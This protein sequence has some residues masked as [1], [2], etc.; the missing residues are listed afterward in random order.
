MS[1]S[2]ELHRGRPMTWEEDER[3]GEDVRAEDIAGP[4][5][6]ARGRGP[7]RQ[8]HDAAARLRQGIEAARVSLTGEEPGEVPLGIGMVHVGLAAVLA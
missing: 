8:Q 7:S 6:V 4:A 3:L 2:A 5:V 1:T